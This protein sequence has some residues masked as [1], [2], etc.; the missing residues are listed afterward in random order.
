[1]SWSN[2]SSLLV[3]LFFVASACAFQPLYYKN[4]VI[5]LAIETRGKQ[6]EGKIEK[7][8][9]LAF[10]K[11][12]KTTYRLKLKLTLG[13]KNVLIQSS[14]DVT[15]KLQTG[16]VRWSLYNKADKALMR[17]TNKVAISFNQTSRN[18]LSRLVAQKDARRKVIKKLSAVIE[19][20]IIAFHQKKAK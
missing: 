6:V 11:K 8:L 7:H 4:E 18:Q 10:P 14:G 13:T 5:G 2:A 9:R 17:H 20:R 3:A 19:Q 1:M 12:N 15:Q 16:V